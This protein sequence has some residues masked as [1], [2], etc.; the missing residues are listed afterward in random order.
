M[1]WSK[2]R[3]HVQ[4][5]LCSLW[6]CK[7]SCFVI[8]MWFLMN[9]VTSFLLHVLRFYWNQWIFNVIAEKFNFRAFYCIFVTILKTQRKCTGVFCLT[10]CS[11]V[12]LLLCWISFLCDS[13]RKSYMWQSEDVL[14]GML[15]PSCLCVASL[16]L[17]GCSCL[18]QCLLTGTR[19]LIK[20]KI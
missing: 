16:D 14:D 10:W 12:A 19:C 1:R 4:A 13:V 18:M 8:Q 2:S 3:L 15:I 11:F 20:R 17:K 9:F 6:R 7:I 5:E